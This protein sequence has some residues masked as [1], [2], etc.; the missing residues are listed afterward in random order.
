MARKGRRG[1][2][3][4]ADPIR[5]IRRA[6]R[7][8]LSGLPSPTDVSIDVAPRF[9]ARWT[10]EEVEKVIKA[11][12]EEQDCAGVARELGRTPGA[13]RH[14]RTWACH[15]LKGEYADK[16][17]AWVVADDPKVRANKHDVIL[18]YQVLRKLG[19]LDLPV[20]EQHRLA[21]PLPQ[22]RAGWRGDR[23]Q[24]ALRRQRRQKEWGL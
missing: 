4:D 13:V 23:T 16:W 19:F 5:L 3:E 8:A 9:R 11:S 17:A 12:P 18:V 14:M 6:R 21:K 1:L 2:S 7:E 24:E 20:V 22:P 10:E 15:I